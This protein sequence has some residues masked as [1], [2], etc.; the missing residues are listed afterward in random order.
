MLADDNT[1]IMVVFIHQ[2]REAWRGNLIDP[3]LDLAKT[4][5]KPIVV[6]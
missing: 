4:S 5:Q 1:D 3:V 6:L 2:V